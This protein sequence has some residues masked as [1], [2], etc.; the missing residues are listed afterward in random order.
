MAFDD[1]TTEVR[2]GAP[3][4][5]YKPSRSTCAIALAYVWHHAKD[6]DDFVLI[7]TALGIDD[8]LDEAPA[9]IPRVPST[10]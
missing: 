10:V 4:E 8:L 3:G 5:A 7:S 9:W 2:T 1:N 6:L